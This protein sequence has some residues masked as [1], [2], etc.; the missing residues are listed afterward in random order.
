MEKAFY[1]ENA[2]LDHWKKEL[3]EESINKQVLKSLL[4][5]NKK[6]I[7]ILDIGT[8]SGVQIRRNIDLGLLKNN[9]EIV[10]IDINK[11]DL[12]KSL[13]SFENWAKKKGYKLTKDSFSEAIYKFSLKIKKESYTI[14]LYEESV[15]NLGKKN[16]RVKGSFSLVTGLSLLEHTDMGRCLKSIKQILKKGGFLY[17]PVNYDQHSIFGPTEK[18]RYLEESNLMQL[19]NYSGIDNQ[20][21]GKVTIGNSHCGSLLPR[22]CVKEGFKV[23]DYGSSDWI[24]LADKVKTYSKNKK[25]VLN[26]FVEAFYNVL[27]NSSKEAKEKFDVNK[28]QIEKWFKLRKKQLSLGE[29][30][31][32]CIQ[33]DILCKK[34]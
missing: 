19:F 28:N 30:Y 20:F 15:Y 16:C 8:G 24:I 18:D 5:K 29:L 32:S 13:I 26:F 7:K 4:E 33:K 34:I 31:Y 6:H 17:L 11:E 21:K 3:D 1:Q 12:K 10:G 23:L 2:Y 25:K 9:G 14:T 22:L 27:L